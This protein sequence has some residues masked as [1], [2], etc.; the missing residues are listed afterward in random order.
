MAGTLADIA[1]LASNS[2]FIA[3]VRG[4]MIKRAVELVTSSSPQDV[5]T[6]TQMTSIMKSAAGDAEK[7]AWLVAA[8]N[9]T[10]AASAPTVPV[11]ADTQF[12]VNTQLVLIK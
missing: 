4:A 3:Q 8:G 6:L 7:V 12:A 11:D 10:I 9:P 1:T 2:A 5:Y